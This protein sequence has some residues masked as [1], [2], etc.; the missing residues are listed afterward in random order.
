M[1]EPQVE[2]ASTSTSSTWSL[3]MTDTIRDREEALILDEHLSLLRKLPQE[4]AL[5]EIRTT[6]I[7]VMPILRYAETLLPLR[8]SQPFPQYGLLGGLSNYLQGQEGSGEFGNPDPRIFFNI[9]TPSSTF[10]CGSQ[11]SG[12][13]HTLSCLLENY[14]SGS[15]AA[16]LPKPLTGLVFHYDTFIS[17]YGGSP[18]EAA[19][20]ASDP[21]IKVRVLCSP[22]N[23]STIR[24]T[25]KRFNIDIEPLQIKESDLNTKRMLELMAVKNG[26]PVPLYIHTIYR[27]LREMR[28]VQQASGTQFNYREFKSQVMDSSLAPTQL[29]PLQQRLDALES[30]MPKI[31]VH[32]NQKGKRKEKLQAPNRDKKD[33]SSKPGHLTIVDLSCP[34]VT[35]E[36]ACSLFNICLSLFIEQSIDGGR[37]IALDEA[38]KFMDTSPE[39]LTLTNTLL[40]VIRLQRHLGARIIISTQEPTLSPLLLDLCSTTIVHR[41]TSPGWMQALKSHLAGIMTSGIHTQVDREEDTKRGNTNSSEKGQAPEI[42]DNIVKLR[43]GNALLFSPSAMIGLPQDSLGRLEIRRLRSGY[44]KIT[45]RNRLTTDSGRS[46]MAT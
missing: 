22:T 25:Y 5:P 43:V 33:W 42:F 46:I 32:S 30:F 38:H 27:I 41:F 6:P 9:A 37:V 10:I 35:S 20:L 19:F 40:S 18:C 16:K 39:A 2:P 3:V 1:T 11:G 24:N 28:T 12:K 8:D 15:K 7:F 29:V 36:N 34:C 26:E 17:D 4:H 13:S 14:L 23:I 21:K 31:Q 44:M 45:V